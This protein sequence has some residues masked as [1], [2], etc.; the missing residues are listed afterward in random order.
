MI[1]HVLHRPLLLVPTVTTVIPTR[2]TRVKVPI[3]MTTVRLPKLIRIIVLPVLNP[4]AAKRNKRFYIQVRIRTLLSYSPS[5]WNMP[6]RKASPK[7]HT[8]LQTGQPSI[9]NFYTR[10]PIR[11]HIRRSHVDLI[12]CRPIQAITYSDQNV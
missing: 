11:I 1:E 12:D 3:S 5:T 4:V 6:H 10:Q 2:A 9:Q 7:G 8:H